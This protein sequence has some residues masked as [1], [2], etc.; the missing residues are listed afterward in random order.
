MYEFIC[1]TAL[2]VCIKQNVSCTHYI[3]KTSFTDNEERLPRFQLTINQKI[4]VGTEG[5]SYERKNTFY[6]FK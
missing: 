1:R 2:N 6:D 3:K 4:K 5:I